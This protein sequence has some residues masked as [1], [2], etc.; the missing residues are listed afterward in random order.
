MIARLQSHYGGSPKGWLHLPLAALDAY[1]QM[2]PRVMAEA[3]L[4]RVDEVGVGTGSMKPAHSRDI[5]RTWRKLA[6]GSYSGAVS[7]QSKEERHAS[8]AAA[9]IVVEEL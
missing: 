2:L 4:T 9:G 7:D 5:L 6:R 3:S 1:I 8:I